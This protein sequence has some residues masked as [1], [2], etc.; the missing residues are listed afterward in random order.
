[1]NRYY[2]LLKQLLSVLFVF[3]PFFFSFHKTESL[4]VRQVESA[5]QMHDLTLC[6]TVSHFPFVVFVLIT[7][8]FHHTRQHNICDIGDVLPTATFWCKAARTKAR[9]CMGPASFLFFSFFLFFLH[10]SFLHLVLLRLCS[11]V[12]NQQSWTVAIS[13]KQ[14]C[15]D[16]I[17]LLW[18]L[19]VKAIMSNSTTLSGPSS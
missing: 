1:M 14:K 5:M 2:V 17:A 12:T 7:F 8:R 9:A 6:C 11:A 18:V 3:F 16:T 15:E 4:R 10:R 19:N 13:L